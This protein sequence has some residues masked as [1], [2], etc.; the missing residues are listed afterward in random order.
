MGKADD[1]YKA[2]AAA[3]AALGHAVERYRLALGCCNACGDFFELGSIAIV[4]ID[5]QSR[6]CFE[7]ETCPAEPVDYGSS[8]RNELQSPL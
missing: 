6:T 8:Y 1:L 5:E 2:L 3:E 4:V 7:H